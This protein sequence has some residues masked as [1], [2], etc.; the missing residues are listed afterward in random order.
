MFLSSRI[1]IGTI[2]PIRN[3]RVRRHFGIPLGEHLHTS[4]SCLH[5]LHLVRNFPPICIWYHL[6]S[7][8]IIEIK[9]FDIDDIYIYISCFTAKY[10]PQYTWLEKELSKVNRAETP[11]LIVLLHSPWYNSNSYHYMEG[12]A[13]RVT[14]EPWFVQHKVDLVFAGHVHSY[15]RSVSCSN[16]H[17]VD[18]CQSM[19]QFSKSF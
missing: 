18:L 11:W 10:T 2:H 17:L 12:E 13:M 4:L 14:F 8:K 19:I 1:C 16:L 15:E 6:Q 7:D 3:H 5:T 9:Q